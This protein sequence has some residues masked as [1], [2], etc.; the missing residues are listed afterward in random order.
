MSETWEDTMPDKQW[1]ELDPAERDDVNRLGYLYEGLR[2]HLHFH[3]AMDA[4]VT[5]L[6]GAVEAEFVHR[7]AGIYPPPGHGYPALDP[8]GPEYP[9][10]GW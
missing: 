4:F 8:E 1:F 3:P 7:A 10:Q 5:V 6:V 9:G 2:N